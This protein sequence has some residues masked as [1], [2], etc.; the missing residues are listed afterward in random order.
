[1]PLFAPVPLFV[2]GGG[3][4]RTYDG[5]LTVELASNTTMHLAISIL[6]LPFLVF[7]FPSP[8]GLFIISNFEGH[9]IYMLLS[10]I[11]FEGGG[12]FF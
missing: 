11:I 6:F 9:F 4:I 12:N 5:L 2:G 7:F 8:R 10:F 3:V 1:M